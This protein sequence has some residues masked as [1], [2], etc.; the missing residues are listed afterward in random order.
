MPA[1]CWNCCALMTSL[2]L[3]RFDDARHHRIPAEDCIESRRRGRH[4]GWHVDNPNVGD[5][6][7]ALLQ[8]LLLQEHQKDALQA[9]ADLKTDVIALHVGQG[10]YRAVVWCRDHL[11]GKTARAVAERDERNTLRHRREKDDVGNFGELH[12]AGGDGLDGE[13]AAGDR[14]TVDGEA[15]LGEEPFFERQRARSPH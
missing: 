1:I 15:L 6:E 3:P 13:I 14:L 4:G 5:S 2:P 9:R 11:A 12:R 10:F 8:P 7:V